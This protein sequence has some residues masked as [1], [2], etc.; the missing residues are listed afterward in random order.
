M[1]IGTT[2]TETPFLSEREL[3]ECA[4]LSTTSE[5][6]MMSQSRKEAEDKD[7]QQALKNST[8][9]SEYS[10]ESLLGVTSEMLTG[11]SK[12]GTKTKSCSSSP[13]FSSPR[14]ASE[15]TS[16]GTQTKPNK[17]SKSQ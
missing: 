14:N 15:G 17:K 11:A 4:R 6:D 12:R 3:P 5:E 10:E 7:L 1:R 2:G 9:T 13:P 16:A 8:A